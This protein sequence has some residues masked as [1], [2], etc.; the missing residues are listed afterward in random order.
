MRYKIIWL[1]II[2]GPVLFAQQSFKTFKSFDQVSIAYTDEGNGSPVLLIHGFIS[3]GVSWSQTQLKKDL[4]EKGYRVIIP[5][6]RGNGNSD[7]PQ[8]SS[9]YSNDAEVKD[10]IGL[11]DKLGLNSYASIGYSRGAIILSKLLTTDT[12]I[13]KAVLGG[14]GLDFTNP[15]WDRRIMFQ[16]AF[17][18]QEPLNEHTRGAVN[19]AKSIGADLHIL[20]LLQQFQPVTSIDELYTIKA[21]VLVIAGD[22][23]TD[24]G[25]PKELQTHITGAKLSI[26]QGDHNNT[27]K[28]Q[29]FSDEIISFLKGD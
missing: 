1:F 14:M 12:R 25:N 5:D 26:I 18:G 2:T 21:K 23:D 24:N 19:Y 27:Y 9:A 16:K 10:M 17:T 13:D 4:L 7:H 6:L 22:Q 15:D 3:S 8:K 29:L 11:A 28:S 20:G